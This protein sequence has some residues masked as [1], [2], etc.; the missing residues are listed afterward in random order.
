M[1]KIYF[2]QHAHYHPNGYDDVIYLGIYQHIGYEDIKPIGIYTSIELVEKNIEQC[3]KLS[4]FRELPNDF[5][6]GEYEIDKSFW[7]DGFDL[8]TDIPMWAKDEKMQ[9]NETSKDF[10]IRLCEQK[11]GKNNYPTSLEDEFHKIK[12]FGDYLCKK[13]TL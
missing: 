5:F 4:G 12:R 7:A 8:D 11:Y 3:Q 13:S 2:L 9:E 10:A 1:N 6:V